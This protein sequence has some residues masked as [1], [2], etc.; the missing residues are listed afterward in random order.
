MLSLKRILICA[1]GKKPDVCDVGE[2]CC[3]VGGRVLCHLERFLRLFSA[4]INCVDRYKTSLLMHAIR[5]ANV[6]IIEWLLKRKVNPEGDCLRF[7]PG[8]A[9]YQ[10]ENRPDHCYGGHQ[11]ILHVLMR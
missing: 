6:S 10:H 11:N 1:I 9:T 4:D 3:G 7:V 2:W 5:D 8:H